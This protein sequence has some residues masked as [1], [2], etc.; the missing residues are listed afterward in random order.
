[1]TTFSIMKNS[2]KKFDQHYQL[3]NMVTVT[4]AQYPLYCPMQYQ[5]EQE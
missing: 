2:R 3:F 4:P 5:D 1:M